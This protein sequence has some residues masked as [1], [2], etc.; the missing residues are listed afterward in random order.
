[1]VAREVLATRKPENIRTEN[2]II[3]GMEWRQLEVLYDN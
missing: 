3:D 1:M 2:N